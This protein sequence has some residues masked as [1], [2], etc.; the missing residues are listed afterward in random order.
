MSTARPYASADERPTAALALTR[1]LLI[2]SALGSVALGGVFVAIG[3]FSANVGPDLRNG[4]VML[5]IAGVFI[6]AYL[7]GAIINCI[8][9][10]WLGA[11]VVRPTQPHTCTG[12]V[13]IKYDTP[14]LTKRRRG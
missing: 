13:Q 9:C 10:A 2:T 7:T 8:P 12:R 5:E 1:A 11:W 6:S 14:V 4:R 3:S